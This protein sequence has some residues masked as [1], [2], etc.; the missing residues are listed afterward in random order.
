M[1]RLTSC[2]K[3]LLLVSVFALAAGTGG[4]ASKGEKMVD[5]FSRTRT[6]VAESRA[7][8][9]STLTA[10]RIIRMARGDSLKEAYK[11]YKKSV[12]DLEKSEA[13]AKRRAL[14]FKEQGDTHLQ[15]WQDE[16]KQLKDP[17]I[18]ASVESRRDAVKSNFALV[19]MYTDDVRKAYEPFIAGNKDLVQALSIDLSPAALTGLAPSIDRVTDDGTALDQKLWM[20]QRA[21]D[22]IA[23]GA[24]PLGGP[25]N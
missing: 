2:T 24:S 5:S 21:L 10:L 8:V 1:P 6:S 19:Q 20:L 23:N 7:Q 13:D 25:P 3:L 17:A 22:N 4:C 14:A 15:S 12:D 11:H 16:M 18:K 9:S